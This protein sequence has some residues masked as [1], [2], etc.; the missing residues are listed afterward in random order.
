MCLS[1]FFRSWCFNCGVFFAYLFLRVNIRVCPCEKSRKC[2]RIS[3]LPS[4]LLYPVAAL[5]EIHRQSI[6]A[7][8]SLDRSEVREVRN[9]S[10]SLGAGEGRVAVGFETFPNFPFICYAPNI[11]KL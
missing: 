3:V 7:M 10:I 8:R 1:G 2:E 4:L 5:I 6:L 9:G 11:H